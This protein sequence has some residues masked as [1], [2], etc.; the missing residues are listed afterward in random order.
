MQKYMRWICALG[1]LLAVM[2]VSALAGEKQYGAVNTDQVRLR[3]KMESTDV[4]CMLNTGDTVEIIR[5]DK[6]E[7]TKYYYVTCHHPNHP[8][9]EYW[10]Y[11]DQRYLTPVA[12]G[13]ALPTAT[14]APV[15]TAAPIAA[16]LPETV[17]S[18]AVTAAPAA[19][20][21]SGSI[22]FTARGVNLRKRPSLEAK[23]LGQFAQDQVIAYYGTVTSEGA[24]WY[25]VE[26]GY[27]MAKYAQIVSGSVAA[28]AA[29]ATP[30][31]AVSTVPAVSNTA[32]AA[33]GYALTT[34]EKVIVRAEGRSNGTQIKLLNRS[35]QLCTLLGPTNE[36]N[37][38][39][40]YNVSVKNITGWI[41][42]DLL[43]FL[44]ES[45]AAAYVNTAAST[46]TITLYTPEK[47][48]WNTGSVQSVFKKGSVA[49][50]TDVKTGISFQVKRWSGG[51]H[52]DVEPLTSSDTAAM[53]KI[54]G[55]STAQQIADNNLYQRRAILVTVGGHT[56]AASMYGVPHNAIEGNT[57][58]DNNY[59]GQFCIHFTNSTTH[60]T[61]VVDSD[62]QN[63]IN[64]AYENGVDKLSGLGY[65]F[66]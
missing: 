6:Y 26:G 17:L 10:G 31:P 24:L 57:I 62:H 43:R 15:P 54:Y 60:G 29:T 52:A 53:C 34:L 20:G 27:V 47:S 61:K 3:K 40:W 1:L 7:G 37:G 2:L 33:S 23:V 46:G 42:G 4:W 39:T 13:Q 14:P 36:A 51:D 32:S 38:Y 55:V 64:Y 48:D 11:I 18:P 44:S 8:E 41:R 50:V 28:P 56:Y 25:Q 9:R 16:A 12:A 21:T 19:S 59:N 22:R 5:T 45:E 30:V 65:V 58:K 35:G 66:Q 63:A 49:T